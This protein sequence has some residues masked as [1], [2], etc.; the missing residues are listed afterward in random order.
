LSDANEVQLKRGVL[1]LCVLA[2]L[3]T[4]DNYAYEI[5]T[6]L[7][8][9]IGMGEGTIY[10]LMRRMQTEGLLENYLVDSPTGPPRRYYR[11]TRAGRARLQAQRESWQ[12]F[13]RA[14]DRIVRSAR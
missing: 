1:E 8:R 12:T 3:A 7:A 9:E 2:H 10:P 6:F 11:V 5:A 13:S 14:I 4:A